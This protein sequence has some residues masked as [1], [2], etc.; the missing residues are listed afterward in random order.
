MEFTGQR[1]QWM[2]A[3]YNPHE[4]GLSELVAGPTHGVVLVHSSTYLA[5]R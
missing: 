1:A 2:N 5:P 3:W 4:R